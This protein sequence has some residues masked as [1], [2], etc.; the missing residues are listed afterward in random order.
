MALAGRW[1]MQNLAG[2]THAGNLVDTIALEELQELPPRLGCSFVPRDERIAQ[3]G[4]V[5]FVGQRER[6]GRLRGARGGGAPRCQVLAH[7]EGT[8]A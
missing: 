2:W 8:R 4:H 1:R 7:L 6:S 3:Y 5:L